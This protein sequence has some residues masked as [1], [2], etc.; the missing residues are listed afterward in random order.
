MNIERKWRRWGGQ[1]AAGESSEI[2]D[3]RTRENRPRGPTAAAA[4]VWGLGKEGKKRVPEMAAIEL[5]QW[6]FMYSRYRARSYY[7]RRA[8]LFFPSFLPAPYLLPPAFLFFSSPARFLEEERE[9]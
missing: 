9:C 1:K 4:R 5:I 3:V 2:T 6:P 8:A 7:L